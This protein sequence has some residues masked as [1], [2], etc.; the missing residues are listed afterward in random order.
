MAYLVPMRLA[1]REPGEG[2]HRALKLGEQLETA[3]EVARTQ[4]RALRWKLPGTPL[5]GL[6]KRQRKKLLEEQLMAAR[7]PAKTRQEVP[8]EEQPGTLLEGLPKKLLVELE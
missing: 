3:Q 5:A 4:Q 6:L 2:L 8:R 7:E 1:Q